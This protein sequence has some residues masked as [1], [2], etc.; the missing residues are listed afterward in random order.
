LS[1]HSCNTQNSFRFSVCRW[2]NNIVRDH[3]IQVIFSWIYIL[4][5]V[6]SC[7]TS[8]PSWCISG[9]NITLYKYYVKNKS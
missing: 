1:C 9:N 3:V 5:H 2:Y 7:D 4:L 8:N 6:Y